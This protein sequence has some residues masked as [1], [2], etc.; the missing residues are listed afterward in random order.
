MPAILASPEAEI[1]MGDQ[2][3]E[4]K[5]GKRGEERKGRKGRR[6]GEGRGGG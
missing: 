3:G 1:R 6:E 2:R 5:E 4:K